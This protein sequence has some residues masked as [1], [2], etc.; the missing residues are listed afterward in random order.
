MTD[1]SQMRQGGQI[2]KYSVILVCGNYNGLIGFAKAKAPAVPV[3]LRKVSGWPI[4]YG[5][6]DI[7]SYLL[8]AIWLINNSKSD[9]L[10]SILWKSHFKKAIQSLEHTTH[11]S[12]FPA[13]GTWFYFFVL[14]FV[15]I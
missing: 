3:A 12:Y 4:L 8:S 14:N 10:N 15:S 9:N 5:L 1:K 13:K 11:H 7:E 6:L 2:A